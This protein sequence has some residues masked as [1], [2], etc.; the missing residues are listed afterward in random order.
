MELRSLT[1]PSIPALPAAF[2]ENEV[3]VIHV[4]AEPDPDD[5]DVGYAQL[6]SEFNSETADGERQAARDRYA[7]RTGEAA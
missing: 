2:P 5:L 7:G 4:E 1:K 6:A 3:E